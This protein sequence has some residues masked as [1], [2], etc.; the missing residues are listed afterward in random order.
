MIIYNIVFYIFASIIVFSALMVV[1]A[2]NP[3]HSVLFLILAFFNAAG[4]F[5]MRGAEFLA[6]TLVIVYVGAVAVLFLFVVMM[7][8]I[9]IDDVKRKF[10]RYFLM[11]LLLGL[12]L[13]VELVLAINGQNGLYQSAQEITITDNTREIGMLLY[14][15]YAYMFEAVGM[16]L[17]LAMM[18]AIVLTLR[19]RTGVL[20]Q[21]IN[22][23]NSR[24]RDS[25]R[26]VDPLAKNNNRGKNDA[27]EQN[28]TKQHNRGQK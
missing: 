27:N 19:K 10:G 22:T 26:L 4:L 2:R 25:V 20:R 17:L 21:N 5:L 12:L 7:L 9:Q 14:T 1:V 11:S 18:G 23:Q 24:T 15:E 13:L 3:V 28:N 16:I 6:M 8:D